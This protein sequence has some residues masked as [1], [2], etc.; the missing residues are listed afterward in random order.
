[1][2]VK[3]KKLHIDKSNEE[4]DSLTKE[5]LVRATSPAVRKASQEAMKIKGFVIKA[6]NGWVVREDKNGTITQ[7]LPTEPVNRSRP[8]ALD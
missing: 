6:E 4:N 1:M 2:K 5:V 3:K 8:I 7:L